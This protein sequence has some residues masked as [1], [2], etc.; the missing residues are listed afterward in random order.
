MEKEKEKGESGSDP[1]LPARSEKKNIVK[2]AILNVVNIPLNA[3]V[4][5]ESAGTGLCQVAAVH[6]SPGRTVRLSPAPTAGAPVALTQY[7]AS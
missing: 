4:H 5:P 3:V 7:N 1:S 6:R 2:D